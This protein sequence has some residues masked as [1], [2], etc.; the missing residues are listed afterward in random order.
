MAFN[1]FAKAELISPAITLGTLGVDGARAHGCSKEITDLNIVRDLGRG[2]L[3]SV[4]VV[5]DDDD[6]DFAGP[7]SY[8]TQYGGQQPPFN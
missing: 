3:Y 8:A 7:Q 1:I 6:D 5:T 4:V 2:L